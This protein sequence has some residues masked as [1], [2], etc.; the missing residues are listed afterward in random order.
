MRDNSPQIRQRA[1]LGRKQGI[2]ITN[3]RILIV[4]EGLKTEKFYFQGIGQVLRLPSLAFRVVPSDWGT[5][6]EKVVA[7]GEFLSKTDSWDEVYCVFDRDDHQY[8]DEALRKAKLLESSLKNKEKNQVFFQAIPSNPCFELWYLI[9][10]ENL[11]REEH[12]DAVQNKLKKYIPDYEK[13]LRHMW[14]LLYPDKEKAI[15]HALVLRKRKEETNNPN[16]STDVD[17]LIS[18]LLKISK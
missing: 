7:Y 10:Y 2:K 8:Y 14:N 4:C 3:P 1:K 6:P 15:A 13:N 9:H 11:T 17:L 18:R 5:T 16:P 12:R